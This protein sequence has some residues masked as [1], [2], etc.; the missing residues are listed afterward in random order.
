M[1]VNEAAHSGFLVAMMAAEVFNLSKVKSKITRRAKVDIL[2]YS[3][4]YLGSGVHEHTARRLFLHH[5]YAKLTRNGGLSL[6]IVF[7]KLTQIW[8]KKPFM[9]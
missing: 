1:A 8:K 4:R 2:R 5:L 7:M 3:P 6:N 9:E